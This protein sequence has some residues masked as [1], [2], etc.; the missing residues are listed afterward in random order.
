MY[1]AQKFLIYH[2]VRFFFQSVLCINHSS[3]IHSSHCDLSELIFADLVEKTEATV[4]ENEDVEI[5]RK[6]DKMSSIQRLF[7]NDLVFISF[8]VVGWWEGG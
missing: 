5:N 2:F 1:F 3:V 4:Q 7:P 8:G 6:K